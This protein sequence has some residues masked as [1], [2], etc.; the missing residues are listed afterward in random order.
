MHF[1]LHMGVVLK[2][3]MALSYPGD[4]SFEAEA[5]QVWFTACW[6]PHV[7]VPTA[8]TTIVLFTALLDALGNVAPFADVP[9]EA[10][11]LCPCSVRP[12][13]QDEV[14][15]RETRRRAR[16]IADL[17]AHEGEDTEIRLWLRFHELLLPFAR[18]SHDDTAPG[19][20]GLSRVRPALDMVRKAHGVVTVDDAAQRCGLGRRRF[21]QLFQQSFGVGF[22]RFAL[23][24][25]LS[26][27]AT[28]LR[29]NDEPV[30]QVA[31]KW[32]FYDASHFHRA[33]VTHFGAKPT[34]FR[35]TH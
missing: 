35:H 28:D 18:L 17:I 32:G 22:G 30:K 31:A 16:E 24:A 27:A 9:W 33:F 8:E 6:E 23:R 15:R 1:A 2:G 13:A 7:G 14:L 26:G 11:F 19:G 4:V 20:T 21:C 12:Q 10:P 25:R 5:G 29:S 3:G 34:T